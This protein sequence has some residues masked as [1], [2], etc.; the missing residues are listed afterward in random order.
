MNK[1]TI[2]LANSISLNQMADLIRIFSDRIGVFVGSAGVLKK[3]LKD[4]G[5]GGIDGE[6]VN[7]EVDDYEFFVDSELNED[8][9][10]VTN[11]ATIQIN[12]AFTSPDHA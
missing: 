3:H 11:G 8:N 7:R 4:R 9:P 2:E 12:L 5:I 10:V 1:E 6:G